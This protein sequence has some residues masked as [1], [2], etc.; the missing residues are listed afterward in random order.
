MHARTAI[1]A[2]V[3]TA[4]LLAGCLGQSAV[5]PEGL[6]IPALPAQLPRFEY[7]CPGQE[8]SRSTAC[9]TELTRDDATLQ[10]P[11]VAVHPTDPAIMAVG[12]NYG[13]SLI[14]R[15]QNAPEKGLEV[16]KLAIYVTKDGGKSWDETFAPPPPYDLS[17]LPV[18]TTPCAGDP[19]L[20]FDPQ[21]RLHVTGIAA[22]LPITD[23]LPVVGA[24]DGGFRTFYVRS[25]DLGATWTDPLFLDDN[26]PQDRN[27]ITRDPATGAL[28][29]V[30]QNTAGMLTN[31]TTEV[32]WSTDDGA[33][34]EHPDA[35]QLP[36]C[37]TDGPVVMHAG[38]P[39]FTCSNTTEQQEARVQ[40]F[41]LDPATGDSTM[42]SQLVEQGYW[43]VLNKLADG[44][45]VLR[46]DDFTGDTQLLWSNDG[47]RTWSAPSSLRGLTDGAWD[48]V[49][50]YWAEADPWGGLHILA[51]LERPMGEP[52]VVGD[53][54]LFEYEIRHVVIDRDG[55]VSQETPL[56][57]WSTLDPPPIRLAEA[58]GDHYYGIAW[59]PDAALLAF[60]RN[61]AV[62]LTETV[63]VLPVPTATA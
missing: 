2:L 36:L 45:L 56:A 38:Q 14:E 9:I 58:L 25:D 31:W 52:P 39:L 26:G 40:V 60:T 28:F 4:P 21:G 11:Y 8:D 43:P 49:Q 5:T 16:C 34:W 10:E 59:G 6:P 42:R 35:A 47:G 48:M 57:A 29:V 63:P 23:N 13:P 61:A 33:T 51:V 20:V 55:A 50:A 18:L 54:L 7:R 27:W 15:V 30:W 44:K 22:P 53:L 62:Q 17:P 1:L 46:Y 19:A 3:V 41:V 24:T 32:A 37:H 12:V